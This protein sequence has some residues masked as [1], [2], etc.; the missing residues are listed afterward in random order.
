TVQPRVSRHGYGPSRVGLDPSG[1]V[2][3]ALRIRDVTHCA[4][5]WAVTTTGG[6]TISVLAQP[7]IPTPF[8]S[9]ADRDSTSPPQTSFRPNLVR[10]ARA[11]SR[12]CQPDHATRKVLRSGG[13]SGLVA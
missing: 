2:E 1:F 8:K 5:S 3:R 9:C 12:L 10:Y 11:W 13:T 4:A 7:G 6:T